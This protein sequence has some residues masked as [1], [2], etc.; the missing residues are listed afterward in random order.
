ME[1]VFYTEP[2]S[3]TAELYNVVVIAIA[4]GL[5]KYIIEMFILKKLAYSIFIA[6]VESQ[7]H[8]SKTANP[9]CLNKAKLTASK[10]QAT[11]FRFFMHSVITV[12]GVVS[13]YNSTWF[14][15]SKLWFIEGY[16]VELSA[17]NRA[18]YLVDAG[19]YLFQLF[20]VNFETKQSDYIMMVLHHVVT[21]TLIGISY[22]MR[23]TR[24]GE[25]VMLLH[26]ICDPALELAKLFLY[27]DYAQ[28]RDFFFSVF[29]LLFV[30]CRDIT[31][32]LLVLRGIVVDAYL[33]D[34]TR[35]DMVYECLFFLSILQVLNFIWTYMIYRSATQPKLTDIRDAPTAT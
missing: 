9:T 34:G 24:V 10:F 8:S 1:W 35:P 5:A 31:F 14:W 25:V 13:A 26:D 4:F 21:L 28:L 6:P 3:L 15:N 29:A 27:L 33:P 22:W 20:S 12:M 2:T 18:H 11:G 23:Q 32:P 30:I 19:A 17:Y 16:N 7:N